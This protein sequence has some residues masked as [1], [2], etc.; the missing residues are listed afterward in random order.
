MESVAVAYPH[1]DHVLLHLSDGHLAGAGLLCNE[2]DAG[3][4]LALAFTAVEASGLRPEPAIFIG[5]L[6]GRGE[7]EACRTLRVAA[8]VWA[9]N[10]AA[11]LIRAAGNHDDRGQVRHPLMDE[12]F[13]SSPLD[14]RYEP[15][16]LRLL[17]L[18]SSVPG[19]HQGEADECQRRWLAALHPPAPGERT[20]K[21]PGGTTT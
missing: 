18:E 13:D 15:G 16:W 11:K 17:A 9:G 5:D 8:E 12:S 7:P 19:F 2:V 4:R 14:R 20:G 1:P 6:A 3:E 21:P 10:V